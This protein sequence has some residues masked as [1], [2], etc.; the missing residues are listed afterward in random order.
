MLSLLASATSVAVREE[1]IKK[2]Q[3]CR[4]EISN[5]HTTAGP[6]T[7][8]PAFFFNLYVPKTYAVEKTPVHTSQMKTRAQQNFSQR[9]LPR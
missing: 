8:L 7:E 5:V 4:R 1:Q 6:T 9:W 2:Q 3:A